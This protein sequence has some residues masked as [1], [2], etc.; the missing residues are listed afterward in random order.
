M[1]KKSQGKLSME[2]D[3]RRNR[4]HMGETESGLPRREHGR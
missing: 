4:R 2:V 3:R 1:K